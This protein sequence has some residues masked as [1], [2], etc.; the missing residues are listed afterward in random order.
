MLALLLIAGTLNSVEAQNTAGAQWV[1]GGGGG[2]V[3]RAAHRGSFGWNLQVARMLQP[4]PALYVEPG[5]LLQRYGR[6]APSN[7]LC[8]PEGCPPPLENALSIVGPEV[9]VAYREAGRNP[10]Y[11]VAGIGV[12]RVSSQDTSGV[13]FGTTLGIGISLRRSGIGPAVDF[14]Y[15]RIFGDPRFHDVFPLALRWSF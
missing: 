10:V 11:P 13:K 4:A 14:R 9:R 15:L 1:V 2:A 12:Y 6:S 8:P 3:I 5:I 7:G